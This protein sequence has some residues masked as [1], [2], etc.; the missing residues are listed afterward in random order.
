VTDTQASSPGS[1]TLEELIALNDEIAALARAGVP[2]HSGLAEL[3]ADMPGRLGRFA[4]IV[5]RRTARGDSLEE[6]FL[7]FSSELPKVYLAV[8]RA[9]LRT[10]RLPSAL[11]A[12][13]TSIRR[14]SQ[15]RRGV[16][17]AMLYPL[18]IFV[19]AWAFFAFFTVK[20]APNLLLGFDR[21]EVAGRGL[22]VAVAALGSSAVYWGP[23]VPLILVVLVG[24]WWYRATRATAA[25]PRWSAALF[26]WM[27]WMGSTLRLSRA[28]T[29]V[30]ILALLVESRV[31]LH[32]GVLLAGEASGDAA[33][34]PA[35]RALADRLQRGES[36]CAE[37][38][39]RS[40][41]AFPPL[42]RWLIAAGRR[43]DALLPALRHAAETYRRRA[44]QQAALARVFLP[45]LLLIAVGG[46]VALLYAL[47]L[48]VPYVSMLKAL[49]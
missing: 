25:E 27:P 7:E 1:V 39:R 31:P 41:T 20:V 22:F 4:T 49:T 30:E 43:R 23:A 18:L 17:A 13:A 21:L 44:E 8:V 16:A 37:E 11:E 42:L 12:L 2:L 19:L 46:G 24:A 45:V 32:E 3:G 36:P 15:T 35:A 29:F 10:G 26:G 47:T 28:A 34:M 6:I 40:G 9:G 5:A 33:L 14:V 48:F 38:L